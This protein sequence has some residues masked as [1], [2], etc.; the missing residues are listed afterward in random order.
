MTA[1]TNLLHGAYS[2]RPLT[3]VASECYAYLQDCQ[4]FYNM[5]DVVKA[6][7]ITDL[8]DAFEPRP[9]CSPAIRGCASNLDSTETLTQALSTDVNDTAL[10]WCGVHLAYFMRPE[11]N[12]RF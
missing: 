9:L 6:F 11:H 7:N 3:S 4:R 1:M 2:P 5:L 8:E 12:R 10:R